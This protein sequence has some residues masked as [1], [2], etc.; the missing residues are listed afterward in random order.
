MSKNNKI[1]FKYNLSD[2]EKEQIIKF[3]NSFEFISINQFTCWEEINNPE[4][5]ICY[6]IKKYG[7]KIIS[8]SVILENK[9][10]AYI[11][12]GPVSDNNDE[13][14]FAIKEIRQYYK[15]K[16]FFKL[17][18]KLGV[19]NDDVDLIQS[20]FNYKQSNYPY[21]WS[22]LIID[23]RQTTIDGIF[24]RFSK[25]HKRSIKK[26]IK[27]NLSVEQIAD[28]KEVRQ[29][30]DIYDKMYDN[31]KIVKSFKNTY[32]VFSGINDLFK[33][34]NNGVILGVFKGKKLVGGLILPIQGNT[35]YYQYG[36]ADVENRNI[37]ILHLGFFEAIK[38]AQQKQ[39]HFFDFGGYIQTVDKNNQIYNINRFKEG[40]K[41]EVLYY[42]PNMHFVLSPVKY[43]I[44]EILRK[45]YFTI[46][47]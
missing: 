17:V 16:R 44:Y 28:D 34:N 5:N 35:L 22:T 42:P 39:L 23:V 37:P 46:F 24:K 2:K 19:L 7:N 20:K 36:V 4:K 1:L 11:N 47:R 18:V 8:Y 33:K 40:F 41:G 25:N 26:A 6:F 29:L 45:L 32:N 27:N 13:I 3:Y 10:I 31:R 12:Y 21:N 15:T 9:K 30:S 43:F 14:A 38:F